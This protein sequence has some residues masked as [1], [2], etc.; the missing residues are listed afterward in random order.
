[1]RASVS[2]SRKTRRGAEISPAG[3][4]GALHPESRGEELSEELNALAALAHAKDG[5]LN[6]AGH[7]LRAEL[8]A[9][10]IWL[11]VLRH[12]NTD[13]EKAAQAMEVIEASS[14]RLAYLLDELQDTMSILSGRLKLETQPLRLSAVV[15][16]AA[17]AT[18]AAADA[19]G[20]TVVSFLEPD[21]S[22]VFGDAARLQQIVENLL[23]NAIKFT[24]EN[25][26]I[27]IR[28]EASGGRARLSVIDSGQ[29]ISPE[30]LPLVFARA[31]RPESEA[32]SRGGKPGLG[33][34]IA[35]ELV[36][37]H[38]GTLEASSPGQGKGSTF[39]VTIPLRNAEPPA[40]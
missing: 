16:A 37:L 18:R 3:T 29:G 32:R 1:M 31:P 11:A 35:H 20:I 28:L 34:A 17:D 33:L 10:F 15:E 26:R 38:G 40:P 23:S 6:K 30:L 7:D 36:R 24:P 9:I 25:G 5:F 14:R 19:R 13:K 2:R 4:S 39:T 21:A 22:L 12:S 27:S 8:S